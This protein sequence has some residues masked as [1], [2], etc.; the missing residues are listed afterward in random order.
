M[1][2]PLTTV[3]LHENFKIEM[4][5][6]QA[7]MYHAQIIRT[8][9][10]YRERYARTPGGIILGFRPFVGLCRHH[11]WNFGHSFR[12]TFEEIRTCNGIPLIVNPSDDEMIVAVPGMGDVDLIVNIYHE[13]KSA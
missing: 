7:E 12:K 3:F 9:H 8:V 2:D 5:E 13:R 11:S 1:K 10:E 6:E 4:T